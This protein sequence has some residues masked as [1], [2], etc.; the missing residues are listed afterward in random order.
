MDER[1]ER[2][3]LK[4]AFDTT[5]SGIQGDPWL[6]QR[7]LAEAK[8]EVEVKKKLSVG[9]VL[10]IVLVL[11]AVTALA[12]MTLNALYERTLE[13]EGQS[14]LIQDWSASDKVALVDWMV[15]A[16]IELDEEQVAKLHESSMS[17]ADKG[18]LAMEIIG[19]YYPARDGILTSVDLIAKEKGPIEYWSLE[20]K[21]W[22]SEMM[23]KYQPEEVSSVNLLPTEDDIT[24]EQ[25]IEIMYAYYEKEYG[26]KREDFDESKMSVTFS[27]NTWD[28]GSGPQ[29]LKTWGINLWLKA[30]AEHPMSIHILP[31]GTIRQASGPYVETWSDDWY[32]TYMS[33]GFWTVDGLYQFAQVWKPRVE[34]LLMQDEQLPQDLEYLITLP[35]GLPK[36]TDITRDEAYELAKES[37]LNNGFDES[38]LGLYGTREAYLNGTLDEGYFKF[39]FTYWVYPLSDE[40]RVKGEDLHEQGMIPQKIVVC[41]NA[42]DGQIISIEE[43]NNTQGVERLGI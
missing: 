20:D 12:A 11:A 19:G 35:F 24:K 30:D 8:G 21:E 43:N 39:C 18:A 33:N 42:T 2:Q 29:R 25:A 1:K 32:A 16:G 14:G 23:V 9:F 6:A 41:V 26:L 17:D 4:S 15:E 31:D 27:E 34:V 40:R 28:D 38:I 10:V 7:V 37:I 3:R 13:K 5:L 22:F 36:A